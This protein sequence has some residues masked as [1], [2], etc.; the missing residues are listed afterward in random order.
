M[1]PGRCGDF[2]HHGLKTGGLLALPP[3]LLLGEAVDDLAVQSQGA[4]IIGDECGNGFELASAGGVVHE[5]DHAGEAGIDHAMDR[6]RGAHIRDL[7]ARLHEVAHQEV[8]RALTNRAGDHLSLLVGPGI[9][10]RFGEGYRVHHGTDP[11]AGQLAVKLHE[12]EPQGHGCAR[13]RTNLLLQGV[14]V[15]VDETRSDQAGDPE[16]ILAA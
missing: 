13:A 2:G 9:A 6:G 15:Q 11:V 1:S 3:M 4:G 14:R 16:D 7:V 8:G 5:R 12:G 10:V